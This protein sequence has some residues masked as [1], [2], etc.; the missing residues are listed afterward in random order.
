MTV[1]SIP[2][3]LG[4]EGSPGRNVGAELFVVATHKVRGG[5]GGP[6]EWSPYGV[7]HAWRPGTRQTLCGEYTNGWTVFWERHF[8][9]RTAA[10]CAGCV[11]M[12]LPAESRARL[13]PIAREAS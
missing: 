3:A 2:G 13:D 7:Q 8:N 1:T 5:A 12:T 10:S 6:G 4:G 11:E 9:A